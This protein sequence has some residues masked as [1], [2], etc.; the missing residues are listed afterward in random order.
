MMVMLANAFSST[1]VAG[2]PP[3]VGCNP[4]RTYRVTDERLAHAQH[5]SVL[6]RRRISG[7]W[8]PNVPT[9]AIL[10][11]C[12]DRLLDNR[13]AT[14]IYTTTGRMPFT[15]PATF[16]RTANTIALLTVLG[17]KIPAPASRMLSVPSYA[18]W[19]LTFAAEKVSGCSF[20]GNLA[21]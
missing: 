16:I 1:A 6:T 8:M 17:L 18:G 3:H 2:S 20:T 12:C 10:G 9:G 5:C 21:R 19:R 14:G 13:I 11:H 15:G 4:R 7:R